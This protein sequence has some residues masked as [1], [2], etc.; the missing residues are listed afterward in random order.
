MKQKDLLNIA[1]ATTN[2]GSNITI[3]AD[4]GYMITEWKEGSDI[5]TFNSFRKA[6]MPIKNTYPDYRTITKEE[7]DR[8]Y[9]EKDKIINANLLN[10]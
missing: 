3:E 1:H 4:A 7:S 9:M 2:V 5:A 10:K 8:L 6:Y